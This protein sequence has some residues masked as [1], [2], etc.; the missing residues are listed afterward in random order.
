MLLRRKGAAMASERVNPAISLT[1]LIV[2]SISFGLT[3]VAT[4]QTQNLTQQR[5]EASFET[6][7]EDSELALLYRIRKYQQGLH[8]GAG[9]L[10]ATGE[11]NAAQWATYVENLDLEASLPGINGIGFIEPASANDVS[12]FINDVRRSGL[13]AFTINP[14]AGLEERFVIR[15]I[16]PLAPNIQALGLD[17]A[18][19]SNRRTAAITARD[20][21]NAAI[22]KRITLVQDETRSVGFLLLR[23]LYRT[24]QIPPNQE[25]RRANFWGWVYAPFVAK[26]FLDNLTQTQGSRLN[27]SVY[28][29]PRLDEAQLI[30]SSTAASNRAGT[31][32]Y[33]K[34]KRIAVFG[35]VW[36]LQWQSTATF[37]NTLIEGGDKIVLFGGLLLT[38]IIAKVLY[39]HARREDKIRRLVDIKTL[40]NK[41]IEE[42]F[43]LALHDAP[44]GMALISHDGDWLSVNKSMCDYFGY[45][46][47]TLRSL[48][49]ALVLG[50]DDPRA[51]DKT[52]SDLKQ[53][54]ISVYRDETQFRHKNGC[55]IWGLMSM[56]VVNDAHNNAECFLVQIMDITERKGMD[57]MKSDFISVVSHE[58]R[59]PLTSIRGSIGLLNGTL[60]KTL[61]T[62]ASKML[63]IAYKNCER[64]IRLVNDI[65]DLD[66]LGNGELRLNMI[67]DTIASVIERTTITNQAFAD[68]FGITLVACNDAPEAKINVDPLRLEQIL[69][70]FLSNAAKFSHPDRDVL[71]HVQSK[72][73]RL[74]ISVT[75]EGAG[76]SESFKGK[77]FAQFSQAHAPET[78]DFSGSGLGLHI[79]RELAHRMGGNIGYESVEK[80]HTTFWVE[81]P[82]A[83]QGRNI[84]S[85]FNHKARRPLV[86]HIDADCHFSASV[87]GALHGEMTFVNKPSFREGL[88]ALTTIPFDL[89]LIDAS[90]P[91]GEG[92]DIIS[93]CTRQDISIMLFAAPDHDI[94]D[95]RIIARFDKAQSNHQDV[96]RTLGKSANPKRPAQA[97]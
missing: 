43:L 16:E 20:T 37:D 5:N 80:K 62:S 51:V 72:A 57:K 67:E 9:L 14:P 15:L 96:I 55:P 36:T 39:S 21:G 24:S 50:P 42:H 60:T 11:A 1:M 4:T 79:S 18:F 45:S 56:S 75:N 53:G 22:T 65:L 40:E 76:I 61:P 7:T 34:I 12:G 6:L 25:A 31:A 82:I 44:N 17:I 8:G 74:R 84:A 95:P 27:L 89:L 66:Q 47:D 32:K 28:D 26:E 10:Q 63:D 19:E 48:D 77:V 91:D 23:P 41:A 86:L 29:G 58:L 69:A 54:E 71:L 90:L 59:T 85:G 52:I 13:P 94:T 46:E 64:L 87:S 70:N 83:G 35:Q 88:S 81:F 97:A 38:I 93:A 49:L 92:S 3:L 2:I 33:S 30:Y 73:D 78:R 68:Q